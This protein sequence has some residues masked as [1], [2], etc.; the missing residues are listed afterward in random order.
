VRA[1]INFF[2]K[3]W[4]IQLIGIIALTLLLWFFASYVAIN[5]KVPLETEMARLITIMVILVLWSLNNLR[6]STKPARANQKMSDDLSTNAQEEQKP[7]GETEANE[8]VTI[9][10]QNFDYA[11]ETLKNS[12]KKRGKQYLYELPWY[13]I[14]GPSG[15]GKTTALLNSGLEFPLADRFGHSSIQGVGGTRN[16]D[17]WFTEQAVFLDTAGNY[18]TQDSH[19]TVD[20]AAWHGFLDLLKRHRPRRPVNG[21]L[22]TMSL[23]D[24]MK[25]TEAERSLNAKAIRQRVQELYEQFGVRFPIYLLLT[26]VDMIA[27]FNDFFAD[28]TAEERAQVWGVTFPEEEG[29]GI[30]QTDVTLRITKDFDDLLT[31]LNSRLPERIQQER[32]LQRRALIFGFPQRMALL[33]EPIIDF[34]RESFG[35]NRYQAAP[36]LRGAYMISSTQE[37][38]P[39]DR[40]M[41]LLAQMF[42][43][44]RLMPTGFTGQ[45]RSYFVNRLL[46]DVIFTEAELVGA[47]KKVEKRRLL[48]QRCGYGLALLTIIGIGA[49]WANSYHKN[50]QKLSVLNEK[51]THYNKIEKKFWDW[52]SDFTALLKQ[53]DALKAMTQV[54]PNENDIPWS[55][56]FGLYQGEKYQ[57]VAVSS[58]NKLLTQYFLPLI[59]ARLEQRMQ[60]EEGKNLSVLYQLLR[61]YLMLGN[62]EKINAETI[63]PWIKI[64]WQNNYRRPIQ[65]KLAKHLADLLALPLPKMTLNVQLIKELRQK[66]TEIPLAEQIYLR[67]KTE[68]E[69]NKQYDFRLAD[70]LGK[71]G[72]RI[73]TVKDGSYNLQRIPGLF[74]YD[75]FHQIF[76]DESQQAAKEALAQ[77]WVYGKPNVTDKQVLAKLEKQIF[78][79]YFIDFNE[80][81]DTL[82]DNLQIRETDSL[83]QSIAIL[84]AVSGIDSPLD[85]LVNTIAVQSNLT[86]IPDEEAAETAELEKGA[87]AVPNA[88]MQ[89][90][91]KVAKAAGEKVQFVKVPGKEIET[92]FATLAA[93]VAKSTGGS[94][95]MEQIIAD[96]AELNS[97]MADISNAPNPDKAAAKLLTK[98]STGDGNDVIARLQKQANLLPEPI[99]TWVNILAKGNWSIVL[100]GVKE[101]LDTSFQADVSNLC[102]SSLE[103]RY[104]L[105][106]DSEEDV[107]LQDFAK[108]FAPQGILEQFFED[109]LKAL[110]DTTTPKWTLLPQENQTINVNQAMIDQ[111]QNAAAIR[112]IFF[113][114]KEPIPLIKFELKPVFLDAKVTKF[115]LDIEG[116]TLNYRH[117]PLQATNLEWP[118]SRS[119]SVRF[120]FDTLEGKSLT[121]SEEGTWAWF[122]T[123]DAIDIQQLSWDK[124][125]LTFDINGFTARYELR[126]NSVLNPF[127]FNELEKFSCLPKN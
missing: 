44:E 80:Y 31:R 51:I 1:I 39:I 89:K 112:D 15:S 36:M 58:Y 32:D 47:N 72:S 88:K 43:L 35:A 86:K 7:A 101:Q 111:F 96:L 125:L 49:L 71:K 18:T 13:V 98:S 64:D 63:T 27:G 90:L 117:G 99:K 69:A 14:I 16:C 122:K 28:L 41:G 26:K 4:V 10:S 70:T 124:Y 93:L 22:V 33:K 105:S 121:H 74:T 126:A 118:G 17:W 9:L 127:G 56:R 34:L 97:L 106:K 53:M 109:N 57:P 110:V 108:F 6:L 113:Q 60:D 100:E 92:H 91:L 87:K 68:N 29:N 46:K 52:Q 120:G 21:I 45:G 8:E 59:Q 66:L 23:S 61:V 123:L 20:K 30:N 81:W 11:L 77:Q 54:Y 83:E 115:W 42:K 24:L 82:I 119:G 62:P 95:T 75:G 102:T 94:S 73:F 55:M 5:G 48:I 103:G 37:G 79:Y 40:L 114:G 12:S 2:K 107:S 38:T 65:L 84:E 104:P 67:I 3:Q 19:Q 76:L 25:M 50:K 116:Q 78:N 85:K